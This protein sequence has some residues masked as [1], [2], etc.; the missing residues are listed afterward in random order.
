M[1]RS[2]LLLPT[3]VES[4]L[5]A[6]MDGERGS[7]HTSKAGTGSVN[8]LDRLAHY[9]ALANLPNHFFSMTA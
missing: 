9:D 7:H 2:E 5:S 6:K 4:P 3:A 1:Q 8:P